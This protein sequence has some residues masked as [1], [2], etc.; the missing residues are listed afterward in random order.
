M[1]KKATTIFLSILIGCCGVLLLG[2]YSV[3][4][5]NPYAYYSEH[6]N[7]KIDRIKSIQNEH[8]I[9]ES[10][11]F[12]T[13][14][15]WEAN[16]QH[17]PYLVKQ[18]MEKTGI[19][20]I[21]FGGDYIA[22]DYHNTQDALNWMKNCI[23]SFDATEKYAILGNHELNTQH[24]RDTPQISY[25]DSS[26]AVNGSRFDLPYYYVENSDTQVVSIYLNSNDLPNN[27]EQKQWFINRITSYDDNWTALIFTHMFYTNINDEGALLHTAGEALNNLI[28]S[29][30]DNIK[31]SVAGVF[32]GHIHTDHMTTFDDYYTATAT[33]CDSSIAYTLSEYDRSYKTTNDQA[34]DVVQIDTSSK[35][36]YLTRIGA[37]KDREYC[38]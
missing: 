24:W 28:V 17:S 12:I 16:H 15:H 4:A 33:M 25:K 36:V 38:F 6:L 2:C 22:Q 23:Q 34:F 29:S 1:I 35:H 14:L 26:M 32:S 21:N 11:F 30:R 27:E 5:P 10:F 9:V 37:G 7:S 19:N 31:C 18:I 13:D 20:K 3:P 8:D